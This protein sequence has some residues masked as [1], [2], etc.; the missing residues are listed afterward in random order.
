MLTSSTTDYQRLY[1]S[2]TQGDIGSNA[3]ARKLAGMKGIIDRRLGVQ[4]PLEKSFARF[5]QGASEFIFDKTGLKLKPS[6]PSSRLLSIGFGSAFGFFNVSQFVMQGFHVTNIMAIAPKF[7]TIG[8]GITIPIRQILH[9]PDLA[10]ETLGIQRLAKFMG[11][12]EDEIK[13]LV[14]YIKTSGRDMENGRAHV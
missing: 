5:G 12:E 14:E 9:A 11:K 1:Q 8:T 10:S 4:T 3:T 2:I 6:D 13:E 7:G